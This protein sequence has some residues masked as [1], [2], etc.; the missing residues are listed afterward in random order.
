MGRGNWGWGQTAEGCFDVGL[1]VF[2]LLPG[3]PPEGLGLSVVEEAQQD[4]RQQP[5]DR[6]AADVGNRSGWQQLKAKHIKDNLKRGDQGVKQRD[7]ELW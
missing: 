6:T 7:G 1:F 3:P 5:A 4:G 2:F